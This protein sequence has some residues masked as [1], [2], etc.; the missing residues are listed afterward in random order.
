MFTELIITDCRYGRVVH[1]VELFPVFRSKIETVSEMETFKVETDRHY[2]EAPTITPGFSA[3]RR[4]R[5]H[6]T[7]MKNYKYVGIFVDEF[8]SWKELLKH[9]IPTLS[10]VKSSLKVNIRTSEHSL[11]F[12]LLIILLV[13]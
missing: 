11:R 13:Q 5:K 9:F 10:Q 12:H 4:W 7:F 2:N 8:G 1:Y 3:P 6:Q